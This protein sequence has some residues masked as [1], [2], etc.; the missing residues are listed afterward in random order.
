MALKTDI[1]TLLNAKMDR[2]DFLKHVAIGMVAVTGL[3]TML[4]ALTPT[5]QQSRKVSSASSAAG[6]GSSAY[7]GV[8]TS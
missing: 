6:Y 5:Q 1:S 4:R 8:K 2:K 3:S 7:G